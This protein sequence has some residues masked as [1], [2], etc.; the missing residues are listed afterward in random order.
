MCNSNEITKQF[1]L[2]LSEQ[3]VKLILREQK[4]TLAEQRQIEFGECIV[5]RLKYA[6][7]NKVLDVMI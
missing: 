3:D 1:D 5:V 6:A 4:N 2:C 7:E